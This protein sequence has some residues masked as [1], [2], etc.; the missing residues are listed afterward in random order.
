MANNLYSVDDLRKVALK[1]SGELTDGTSDYDILSDDSNGIKDLELLNRLYKALH[2]GG[3]ELNVAFSEDFP[4]LKAT[5]PEV[6]TIIP[7]FETGTISLTQ[8]STSGTLS[9]APA[10]GL[11]S[12]K[13]YYLKIE[14]RET[15][16]RIAAHTAAG[17]AITLDQ[18]Y[19]E[20]TGATLTFKIIKLDYQLSNRM[21]RIY[22]ELRTE[23]RQFDQNNSGEIAFLTEDAFDSQYGRLRLIF[24]TPTVYTIVQDEDDIKTLRF[25][26]S[27]STDK[28]RVE[29]P[30]IPRPEELVS[31]QFATTD[32]SVAA[33]TI[34]ET[35]HG[36]IANQI[37][38]LT[39]TGTVPGGLAVDTNYYVIVTDAN[40]IQLS[41]TRDGTAIDITSTGTGTHTLASVPR[42]PLGYRSLLHDYATYFIMFDK[43]D[44]RADSYL[45]IAQAVLQAM[46][47]EARRTQRKSSRNRGRLIPRLD[48]G[49]P[50][51][52]Y[53][54]RLNDDIT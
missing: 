2:Y 27:P 14:G 29:V 38:R 41:A 31:F 35:A 34:T 54:P 6:L 23:K 39:T 10:A 9:S 21:A 51:N 3:T 45:R 5:L 36:L 53:G 49:Y 22:K 20:A 24:G 12:F 48:D 26:R 17:T 11:G 19:L 18:I 28:L 43:S 42:I 52:Q 8:D 1:Q 4:W 30:Y 50:K 32:V 40:T 47:N 46:I 7:P 44:P 25:N 13:G 33:N 16:Y 37:L 15:V